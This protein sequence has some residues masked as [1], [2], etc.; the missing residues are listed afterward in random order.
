MSQYILPLFLL[1]LAFIIKLSVNR[2]C[3]KTHI[4]SALSELPVDIM[5]LS[6]ALI[7]SYSKLSS[8][9]IIEAFNNKD[10]NLT[11]THL[12]L[13]RGF[14]LFVL[15]MII[16]IVITL[17]WRVTEKQFQNNNWSVFRILFG[18]NYVISIFC[19]LYAISKLSGV[20]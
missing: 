19:L 11:L 16:T 14:Y 7:I 1:A 2:T 9:K 18:I 10:E 12:D 4:I 15:Y 17:I 6:S 3:E 20:I 5:F 8:N 13:D